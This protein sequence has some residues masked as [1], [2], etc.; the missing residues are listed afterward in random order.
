MELKQIKRMLLGI[1]VI[2]YSF[3]TS[4]TALIANI[5]LIIVFSGMFYNEF[6]KAGNA[7]KEAMN[8]NSNDE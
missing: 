1:A 2:M 6:D 4:S 5:G 8:G 3:T 7:I